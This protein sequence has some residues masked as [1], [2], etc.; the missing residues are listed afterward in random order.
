[1]RLLYCV[2]IQL[3][4]T[5]IVLITFVT[6]QETL[7]RF[8]FF[9]KYQLKS[10]VSYFYKFKSY[11]ASLNENKKLEPLVT[12]MLEPFLLFSKAVTAKCNRNLFTANID[13]N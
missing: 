5:L 10:T 7:I 1:M 3:Q 2:I 6:A 9:C 8:F 11:H 12:Q 4:Q 13:N